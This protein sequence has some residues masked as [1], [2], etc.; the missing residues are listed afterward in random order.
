M[1]IY[2]DELAEAQRQ[3]KAAY[4]A[5][6]A[7]VSR[8]LDAP[9]VPGEVLEGYARELRDSRERLKRLIRE[10]GVRDDIEAALAVNEEYH[11]SLG[12]SIRDK[13]DPIDEE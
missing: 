1:S 8:P 13:P 6:E 5:M 7:W 9:D 4:D 12:L 3:A 11:R 2:K 10:Q